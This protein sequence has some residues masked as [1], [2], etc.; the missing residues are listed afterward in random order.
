[1]RPK[2]L[3]DTGPAIPRWL[4]P[5]GVLVAVGVLAGAATPAGADVVAR[6]QFFFSFFAGVVVLVCLSLAVM[7]GVLASD[8]VFLKIKH[9]VL[10]QAVHRALS[11]LAVTFLVTHFL[12]KI[13]TGY[14]QPLNAIIPFDPDLATS[15]G[16]IAGDL[17]IFVSVTGVLRGRFAV[18]RKPTFWRAM[19]ASAYLCWPLAIWHGLVAGR[20]ARG[21]W[22]IWSY[23]LC[24]LAVVLAVLAR[25]LVRIQ[26]PADV[27]PEGTQSMPQP[28]LQKQSEP[29][30][31]A[32][33][34]QQRVAERLRTT[35]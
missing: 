11:L 32:S 9:R 20:P 29:A 35:R 19:H 12:T 3:E 23:A 15:I 8:R 10:A 1:M 16:P 28:T 17:L 25:L 30:A 33:A 13:L 22:V 14:A 21:E 5:V 6:V 24:M 7:V 27:T 26:R 18:A 4:I 34:A 31:R 2:S